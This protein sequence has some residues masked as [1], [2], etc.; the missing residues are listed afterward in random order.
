MK[1]VL[2]LPSFSGRPNFSFPIA[3]DFIRKLIFLARVLID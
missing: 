2:I 3:I 1:F